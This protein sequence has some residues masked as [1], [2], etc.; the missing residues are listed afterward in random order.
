M[1]VESHVTHIV[2][3]AYIHQALMEAMLTYWITL[4]S[5]CRFLAILTLS[6]E[7]PSS[8]MS[9]EST[10]R[11]CFP[12]ESWGENTINVKL[13]SF[14]E[15]EREREKLV[16]WELLFEACLHYMRK[17]SIFKVLLKRM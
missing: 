13:L 9:P 3:R 5:Q 12:T 11:T 2:C 16:M 14:T 10:R 1:F 4:A 7:T 15:M 17:H 6:S 8:Q